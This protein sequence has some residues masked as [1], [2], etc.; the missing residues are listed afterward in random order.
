MRRHL[1][2]AWQNA[3]WMWHSWQIKTRNESGRAGLFIVKRFRW[4]KSM[5]INSGVCGQPS[6]I[7]HMEPSSSL[8]LSLRGE[9]E[10]EPDPCFNLIE[11]LLWPVCQLDKLLQSPPHITHFASFAGKL[12]ECCKLVTCLA[13]IGIYYYIS[14]CRWD[15]IEI[16]QISR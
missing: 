16:S 1:L 7:I 13:A 4:W 9:R 2:K 15:D 14:C 3:I 5:N 12:F 6:Q 10:R 8:F 11:I